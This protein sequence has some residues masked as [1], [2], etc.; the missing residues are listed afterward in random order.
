MD[1]RAVDL[2]ELPVLPRSL[3]HQVVVSLKETKGSRETRNW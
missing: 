3:D 1:L 2:F